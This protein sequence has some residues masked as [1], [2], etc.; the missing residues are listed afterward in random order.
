MHIIKVASKITGEKIDTLISSVGQQD[1]HI[2]KNARIK[3]AGI[4]SK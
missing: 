4:K 3:Y 1:S 2:A